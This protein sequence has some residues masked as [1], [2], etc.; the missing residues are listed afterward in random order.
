MTLVHDGFSRV[1]DQGDYPFGWTDFIE[2][3]KATVETI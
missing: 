2:K 3:L 1:V